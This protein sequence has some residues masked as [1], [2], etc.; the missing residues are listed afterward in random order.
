MTDATFDLI[1]QAASH[2]GRIFV[3]DADETGLALAI[4]LLAR[5]LIVQIV[6]DMTGPDKG[7]WYEMTATGWDLYWRKQKSRT[8]GGAGRQGQ[9]FASK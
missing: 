7:Q 2:E 9:S 8:F 4:E 1:R 5:G 6:G 3:N